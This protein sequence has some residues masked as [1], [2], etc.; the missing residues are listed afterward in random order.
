MKIPTLSPLPNDRVLRS[1]SR[2]IAV[3]AVLA[4]APF[5]IGDDRDLLRESAEDPYVMI[6]MDTSGSMNWNIG[7]LELPYAHADS[8]DSK[9][10]QAKEAMYEVVQNLQGTVNFGFATFNQNDLR[11]RRKHWLYRVAEDGIDILDDPY[12]SGNVVWTYPQRGEIHSFGR[13]IPYSECIEDRD[14]GCWDGDPA[15]LNDEWEYE[16]MLRN[17]KMGMFGTDT[18]FYY[19]RADNSQSTNWR[20]QVIFYPVAGIPGV[21]ATIEVDVRI[22]SWNFSG[23]DTTKRITFELADDLAEDGYVYVDLGANKSTV[24]SPNGRQQFFDHQGSFAGG[25]CDGWDPNDDESDDN[26]RGSSET[27]YVNLKRATT[28]TSLPAVREYGDVIPLNWDDDNFTEVLDRLALN[29]LTFSGDPDTDA[30]FEPDFRIAP[31]LEDFPTDNKLDWIAGVR[32]AGGSTMIPRGSTPLGNS[33]DD[34]KNWY[35]AWDD[36]AATDDADWGCRS[37]YIVFLTDGLET[38]SSN[39]E[40]AARTLFEDLSVQTYVIGFGVE[41]TAGTDSLDEI[42]AAGGTGEPFRPQ[43]PEELVAVLS[44]IFNEI[45]QDATTFAAAAVPSVQQNVADK[46][47]LTTFTPVQVQPIWAGQLDAY[48]KPLPVNSDLTPDRDRIC[49]ATDTSACRAWDAGEELYDQSLSETELIAAIAGSGTPVGPEE[50]RR[51]VYYAPDTAAAG[52]VPLPR[53]DFWL[54]FADSDSD[55][56]DL[57][58]GLGISGYST[59]PSAS[60]TLAKVEGADVL[61]DIYK[62]K[63][64]T[65]TVTDSNGNS[66]T[67]T[68]NYVLGDIFHSDPLVID[69]PNRFDY[70]TLDLE[71]NDRPCDDASSPNPGYRCYFEKHQWRRKVLAVGANDGQL[72]FF[73]SGIIRE[74][75]S[76]GEV[77]RVFDNGTGRE[78]ASIVPR[79][80]MPVIRTQTDFWDDDSTTAPN[81]VGITHQYSVDGP[82]VA[83]DV[84]LDPSHSGTPAAGDREWRTVVFGGMREGGKSVIAVD[85]TQPDVLTTS[86]DPSYT[87]RNIPDPRTGSLDYVPS[88]YDGTTGCGPIPWPSLLWEF[89]DTG[90]EDG[91]GSPDL[92][93]TWSRPVVG[94]VKVENG[95]NTETRHVAI[96]GGGYD[97]NDLDAGNHLY[98]IDVETGAILFKAVLDGAAPATP[99]AIDVAGDDGIFDTVYIGTV[100]GTMYKVDLSTAGTLDTSTGRVSDTDWDPFP[101][102]R[103]YDSSETRPRP[104]FYPAAVIRVSSIDRYAVAFGT[105]DRED[106]W[107]DRTSP[108]TGQFYVVV[109]DAYVQGDVGSSLPLDPDDLTEVD[110]DSTAR[111]SDNY[112]ESGNGWYFE[113][114]DGERQISNPFSIGGVTIFSSYQP[115]VVPT[116]NAACARTGESRVYIVFTTNGNGLQAADGGGFSRYRAISEFI[117]NSYVESSLTQNE[118]NPSSSSNSGQPTT[119]DVLTDSLEALMLELRDL[120]PDNCQFSGAT[121]NLKASRTGTG[122]V[123]IAPIPICIVEHNWREEI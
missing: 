27:T 87:L 123:F 91:N 113:L 70:F 116:T 60:F 24:A 65:V 3:V 63:T 47:Y 106:L 81:N 37:S 92:S 93:F 8:P 112:L 101:M 66:V 50:D 17:P 88:C 57:L 84:F 119:N 52:T 28:N 2:L 22:R 31:F 14:D 110:I 118:S 7:E 23:V 122:Q 103:T 55:W 48:L 30:T 89:T 58:F 62:Q 114:R 19:I 38:C 115:D 49:G 61:V 82:L 69:R 79:D 43:S 13:E 83:Q 11:V 21:D 95:G 86:I 40:T 44:T 32:S 5:A 45:R 98:M 25:T 94:M 104:I 54:E 59:P 121:L 16:R 56:E 68:L 15:R 42:A 105:G 6:L 100:N 99:A 67:E 39:G 74:Q 26:Y 36:I 34:V 10:Y 97:P 77:E 9:M 41:D 96:F 72:H 85:V 35:A 18:T 76:A 71:S 111:S 78:L 46:I 51:R 108:V 109:D 73:D 29:R 120:L 53:S 20:Y 75:T 117:T 33:L 90:D 1:L 80:T 64:E 107:S 12:G 4:L 102:F